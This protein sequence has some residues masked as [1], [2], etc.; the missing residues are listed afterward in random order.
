M[1]D[2]LPTLGWPTISVGLSQLNQT[3]KQ[4]GWLRGFKLFAAPV[5]LRWIQVAFSVVE[6]QKQISVFDV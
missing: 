1:N 5:N 4:K 3:V 6:I 2:D